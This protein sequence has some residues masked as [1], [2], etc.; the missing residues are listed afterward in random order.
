[1][2]VTHP[3]TTQQKVREV[4]SNRVAHE[5]SKESSK[6]KPGHAMSISKHPS[7]RRSVYD[8]L[9]SSTQASV[10]SHSPQGRGAFLP[11]FHPPSRKALKHPGWCNIAATAMGST[12]VPTTSVDQSGTSRRSRS[13]NSPLRAGNGH[14]TI[15]RIQPTP[16]PH[17]KS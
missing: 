8:G 12:L 17:S 9:S 7:A 1:M 13:E 3:V 14:S 6:S 4:L 11:L 5:K 15:S 16:L 2:L 10:V